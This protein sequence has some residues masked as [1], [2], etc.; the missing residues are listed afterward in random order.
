[1]VT[2]DVTVPAGVTLTV[3]PGTVIKGT[4]GAGLTVLGELAAQGTSAV[5]VTFTSIR[6]DSAGGDTDSDGATTAPAA[7]DWS[8]ISIQTGGSATL[9]DVSLR[10]ATRRRRPRTTPT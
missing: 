8:G 4:Q 6:D 9:R 7:G 10:Y 5:P 2:C 3:A 1:M